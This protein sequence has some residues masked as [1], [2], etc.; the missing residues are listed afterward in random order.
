M[1]LSASRIKTFQTCSWLYFCR[2]IL[3]FSYLDEGNDGSRRGTIVHL[4]LECIQNPR[5]HHLIDKFQK[6]GFI[7]NQN[8]YRLVLK[9]A[10]KVGVSDQK[11]MNLMEE[12]IKVGL[13]NDFLCS[14]W[15][16]QKPE[17]KFQ[18]ESENPKF[19][20]LGYI[21]KTSVSPN[22]ETCRIDDY[23]TSKAKFTGK[24]TMFNIQAMIYAL[25]MHKEGGYKKTL[26][27]FIF[28]KFPKNPW[29]RF[30]FNEKVLKGFEVHLSN[31]YSYLSKFTTIKAC[32]NFAK[33]NENY[34]LCGKEEG[35]LKKDGSPAWVCQMKRPFLY[36]EIRDKDKNIKFTSK[37]KEKVLDKMAEGDTIT[38]KY[39]AGCPKFNRL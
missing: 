19:K 14:G 20:I 15:N 24:D 39:Y 23:K 11:N 28:L 26:V 38:Q 18:I 34:F 32:S 31:I 7:G 12:F 13:A 3:G 6:T 29:Q 1:Y 10:K 9:N 4:V 16:L 22:G 2:Y 35:D 25:A 17:Q 8:I 5:R 27:N 21:D 37:E 33:D 36:W 30:E